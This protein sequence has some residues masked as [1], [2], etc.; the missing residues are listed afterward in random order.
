MSCREWHR[1]ISLS[2][3]HP[4]SCCIMWVIWSLLHSY[5]VYCCT[6]SNILYIV[7]TAIF[8][9]VWMS[10]SLLWFICATS[11]R[12]NVSAGCSMCLTGCWHCVC[13]VVMVSVGESGELGTWDGW[14]RWQHA[15]RQALPADTVHRNVRIPQGWWAHCCQ[16]THSRSSRTNVIFCLHLCTFKELLLF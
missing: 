7:V 4:S 15:G 3:P 6:Q 13:C 5:S 1:S 11:D 16:E 8:L 9:K 2:P 14:S 12:V 10:V